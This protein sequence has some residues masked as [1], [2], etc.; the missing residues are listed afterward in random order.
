MCEKN[1]LKLVKEG[2]DVNS[3]VIEVKSEDLQSLI[4][5]PHFNASKMY[6]EALP[7]GIAIGLAYN[8]YGGNIL[9]IET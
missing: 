1:V 5:L 4:G 8:S 6:K 2:N 7:E 9:Y 3:G